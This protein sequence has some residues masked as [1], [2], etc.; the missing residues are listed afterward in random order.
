MQFMLDEQTYRAF[1]E[2]KRLDDQQFEGTGQPWQARCYRTSRL[3]RAAILRWETMFD[4]VP[5]RSEQ[6]GP[7]PHRLRV[8]LDSRTR[9]V[10]NWHA[11]GQFNGNM[12]ATVRAMLCSA[13][14]LEPVVGHPDVVIEHL[15]GAPPA[16]TTF[17]RLIPTP[18]GDTGE[19]LP[20][21]W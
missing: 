14:G 7:F 8:V 15:I 9:L 21:L 5:T 1:R 16:T 3:T 20:M 17:S 2:L 19:S 18:C 10:L 6:T 13:A 4:P 12:S 11:A